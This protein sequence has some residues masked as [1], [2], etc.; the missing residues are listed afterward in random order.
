MN[1]PYLRFISDIFSAKSVVISFA[2]RFLQRTTYANR[3]FKYL[4]SSTIPRNDIT[5][6]QYWSYEQMFSAGSVVISCFLTYVFFFNFIKRTTDGDRSFQYLLPP[7]DHKLTQ[8]NYHMIL[9]NKRIHNCL[10]ICRP[11]IQTSK[12]LINIRFSVRFQ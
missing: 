11:G 1:S 3:S 12:Y 6:Q 2:F 9:L 10:T 8:I 5:Q 4:L 7:L